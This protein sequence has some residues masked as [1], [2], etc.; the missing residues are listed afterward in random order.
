MYDQRL[1]RALDAIHPHLGEIWARL[2]VCAV[3]EWQLDL[4]VLHWDITS[5]YFTGAYTESELL[6][7]GYSRDHR[8]ETKQVNLEAAVTHR[9]R[10][11]VGYRVLPGQTA[12][13]TT[14]AD[15]LQALL[16]FPARPELMDLKLRPIRVSDG[17]MV[18]PQAISDCHHHHYFYLGPLRSNRDVQRLLRSMTTDELAQHELAYRPKRQARDAAFVPYQDGG[19]SWW[20]SFGLV[21]YLPKEYTRPAVFL[22]RLGF[23]E[24]MW[25]YSGKAS[26][27]PP[28]CRLPS[29]GCRPRWRSGSGSSPPCCGP[30]RFTRHTLCHRPRRNRGFDRHR[31]RVPDHQR[32]T[33]ITF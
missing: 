9:T 24:T 26:C 21:C 18:T 3:Q 12:D 6:R 33:T 23:A 27:G 17:K 29:T 14:P 11:P 8:P 1:G 30:G 15:H 13:I 31:N 4:S 28:G 32:I 16:H 5:F 25:H 22:K 19:K 10:V 2:V 7:R 20:F